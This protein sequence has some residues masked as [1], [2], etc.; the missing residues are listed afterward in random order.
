MEQDVLVYDETDERFNLGVGKTRDGRYV[1]ME[2]GSHTT[3]E[4]RFLTATAPEG[5]FRL[6]APR[7]DDQEYSVDHRDGLFYIRVND[8]GKNF[9]VVTAPVAD[10]GRG[11]LEGVHCRRQGSST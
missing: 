7:K 6:I 3:S 4:T 10:P 11:S 1:L 5:R 8:T 9:R 2:A